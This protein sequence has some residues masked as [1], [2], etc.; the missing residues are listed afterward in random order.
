MKETYLSVWYYGL[1]VRLVLLRLE[2]EVICSV[3][4]SSCS[5]PTSKIFINRKID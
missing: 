1:L 5:L 3:T 4:D 2:Q